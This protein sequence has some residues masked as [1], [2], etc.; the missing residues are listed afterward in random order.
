LLLTRDIYKAYKKASFNLKRQYLAFFWERFE[1]A[2]GVI[3]R[4]IP[5]PLFQELLT[6]EEAY[7]KTP[8]S[9]DALNTKDSENGILSNILLPEQ[10]AIISI[11]ADSDYMQSMYNQMLFI[12]AMRKEEMA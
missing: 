3:L 9:K 10:D 6:A 4:S 2:D 12:K 1:V 11:F 5:S 7:F 8:K